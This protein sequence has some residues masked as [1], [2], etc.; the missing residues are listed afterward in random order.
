MG[1][2]LGGLSS[3]PAYAAGFEQQFDVSSPRTDPQQATRSEADR[4]LRLGRQQQALGQSHQT[5][6]SWVQALEL[7][8]RVGDLTAMGVIYQDLAPIYQSLGRHAEAEDAF[9]RRLAIA[10]SNRDFRGQIDG[11]NEL[12]TVLQGQG[13]L[14]GSQELFLEALA[15]ARETSNSSGQGLSLRNLGILA[16]NTRHYDAA[17]QA[18]ESGVSVLRRAEEPILAASTLAHLGD[19]YRLANRPLEALRSYLAARSLARQMGDRPIQLQVIDGL[20]AVYNTTERFPQAL[21]LLEERAQLT[22]NQPDFQQQLVTARSLAQHYQLVGDLTSARR[23]YREAI[24]LARY[25]QDG[26]EAARL[27]H[28]LIGLGPG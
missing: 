2:G 21:E 23:F 8:H 12:G 24:A 13:N 27:F 7:Y 1:L 20:A 28:Q 17:I 15:I 18:L 10:R 16:A 5:V 14:T 22:Q 3:I 4:L 25:L 9:R 26:P 19:A 6:I 11:L